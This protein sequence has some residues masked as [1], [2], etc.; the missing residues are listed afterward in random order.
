MSFQR[1]RMYADGVSMDDSQA[2]APFPRSC[3]VDCTEA[4]RENRS[5]DL[6]SVV[7]GQP[8]LIDGKKV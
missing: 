1:K 8:G 3:D 5:K 4:V 6:L 7:R 2:S